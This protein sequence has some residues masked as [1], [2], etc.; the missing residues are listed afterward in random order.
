MAATYQVGL[1]RVVTLEDRALLNLHGKMIETYYPQL[2]V[3]SQ[4]IPD[5]PHGIHDAATEDLAVPK[6][7]ALAKAW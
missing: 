3:V 6:I 5:Q 2:R 4:S 1:I 7:I